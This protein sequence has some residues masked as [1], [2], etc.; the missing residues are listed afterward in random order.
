[1]TEH[2]ARTKALIRERLRRYHADPA[3]QELLAKRRAQ[4]AQT[5]RDKHV[6]A[7]HAST[8]RQDC[9]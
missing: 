9:G 5:L 3:N 7:R 6:A 8:R 2:S 1:M 4:Q